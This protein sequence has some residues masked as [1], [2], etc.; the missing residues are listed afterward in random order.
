MIDR[1]TKA[2]DA[3]ADKTQH[4]MKVLEEYAIECSI[5]K[6]Y[7]SEALDDVLDQAVQIFGG[8]GFHE[9][10]PVARAYRDSRVN[11]IFE[12][13]NEINRLLII[14]MLMK[15]ALSGALP[16]MAAGAKLQEEVLGGPSFTEATD[17][18]WAEQERILAGA[19]K[20]FL[21]AAGAA[22]QKYREQLADQQEIV[23][24]LA[25]IVIEIYAVESALVRAQKA[26]AA[27]GADASAV[28]RAAAC[29]LLDDGAGRIETHA[30]TALAACVEGDM[31]RT[32]LAVLRRFLKRE[33]VNT[34]ALCQAV[35]AAVEAA[36]RYPF[37]WR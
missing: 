16:L 37:E 1:A 29:V 6:V 10:Y 22:M 23:G 21:L 27:R 9:E 18:P 15:R 20:A 26:E 11:R 14:Q 36:G 28:M 32:Q 31:L 13:T 30:R 34:I 33:P 19:K 3:G 12:G 35:A 17:G 25:D 2:A 8:Y 24:T 5:G 4:L 7:G